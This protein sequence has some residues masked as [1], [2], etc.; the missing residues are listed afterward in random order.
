MSSSKPTLDDLRRQ[1][2]AIDDQMHDLIMR[3]TEIVEAIG[4]EK[5]DGKVP[6]FRPGREAA[7]LRRLVARHSGHFPA[8]ALVRMW[9]EMLAATVGMQANFAI[10]VYAPSAASG[11]WDLARDHFGSFAP[12]TAYHSIG[13]V[14]RA[15]TDKQVSIG[16]LPMPSEDD[17]DPWWRFLVSSDAAA[18]R[19]VARLPFAGRGNARVGGGDALAVGSGTLEPTGA[20]RSLIV[21]ETRGEVSRARLF[22]ALSASGLT[23]NFFAAFDPGGGTKLNLVELTDFVLPG[24]KRLTM[25]S[26]QV[27]A[28]VERI[29]SLGSYGAPLALESPVDRRLADIRPSDVR[30]RPAAHRKPKP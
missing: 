28:A 9:R 3:R 18:P 1:I 21:V 22:S 23:C 26:E 16:V 15:V 30:P 12:M 6:A 4:K 10:A 17:A 11:Y 24:D 7:I 5:K 19:V 13:Q 29:L 25:F 2:D 8:V 27:G 14:I 20:D